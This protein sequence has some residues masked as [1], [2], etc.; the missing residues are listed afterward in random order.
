MKAMPIPLRIFC[1]YIHDNYICLGMMLS[2]GYEIYRAPSSSARG[3]Q[4][5]VRRR[6]W[7]AVRSPGRGAN[8]AMIE[9]DQELWMLR[10]GQ[11]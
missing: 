10:N 11:I 8:A 2:R 4:Q 9:N 6:G 5:E 1:N 3:R 7:A